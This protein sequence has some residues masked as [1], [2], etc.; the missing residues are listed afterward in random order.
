MPR[1]VSVLILAAGA[2][3]RMKGEIKQLLPWGKHTLLEDAIYQAKIVSKNVYVVLGAYAKKILKTVSMNVEVIQN[4]NWEMGMGNSISCGLK[5]IAEI[6]NPEGILIMLADQPLIDATYLREMLKTFDEGK[7][8]IIAT[9]YQSGPGVP[10]IFDNSILPELL[11]LQGDI[12]ARKII[13]NHLLRTKLISPNGKE[14]D[15]DT[16][17]NYLQIIDIQ[18]I[19]YD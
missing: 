1:S 6:E 14:I 7:S 4:N 10:A 18:N 16:K 2:S 3:T 15:V 9:A 19:K 17:E 8:E 12:G 5:H 11:S 13:K